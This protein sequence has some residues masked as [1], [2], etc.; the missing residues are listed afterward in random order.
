[1]NPARS[2]SRGTVTVTVVMAGSRWFASWK[3][4]RAS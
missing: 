2:E 3:G 4:E 1:M